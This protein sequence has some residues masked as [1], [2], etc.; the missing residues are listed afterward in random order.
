[1]VNGDKN[2]G[3]I[4]QI[5]GKDKNHCINDG[6]SN[7]YPCKDTFSYDNYTFSYIYTIIYIY[8]LTIFMNFSKLE[9]HN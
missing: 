9:L 5:Y 6:G 3:D 1:M 8:L 2:R 7:S 4:L